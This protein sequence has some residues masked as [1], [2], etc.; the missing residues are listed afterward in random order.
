MVTVTGCGTATGGVMLGEEDYKWKDIVP[1]CHPGEK[2]WGQID[3]ETPMRTKSVQD[4][5]NVSC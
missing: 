4:S 1:Q 5:E 3:S 2:S